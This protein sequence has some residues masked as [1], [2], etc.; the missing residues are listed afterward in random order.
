MCETLTMPSAE[1]NTTPRE[2][3]N[4]AT[5]QVILTGAFLVALFWMLDGTD[6]DY[7]PPWLAAVLVLPLVVAAFFAERVWLS[8]SPL[9]PGLDAFHLRNAALS[10][11]ASQ[12]IRKMLL[13]E[14]AM[15]PAVIVGFG[16][17]YGAW[18]IVIA[19]FPGMSLL[20]WETWPSLRNTSRTEAML[21]T[22]GVKSG[23]VEAFQAK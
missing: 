15:L 9:E 17:A 10:I 11:Y 19:G 2:I 18:P 7:P 23:L 4:F 21:D 6:A 8:G 20:A 14:A 5:L 13:V 1:Y 22:G 12:T 16:G 3:R